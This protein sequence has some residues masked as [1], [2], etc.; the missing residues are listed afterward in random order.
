MH[1]PD[2]DED[3]GQE[4][5]YEDGNHQTNVAEEYVNELIEKAS[6]VSYSS[7][8]KKAILTK[9]LCIFSPWEMERRKR[10]KKNTEEQR[11]MKRYETNRDG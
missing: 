4:Q 7:S 1:Q 5:V 2:D 6:A 11:E 3:E 8:Q 10:K 9:L